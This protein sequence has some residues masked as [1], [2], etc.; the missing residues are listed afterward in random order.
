MKSM[1]IAA[2]LL[3][4]FSVFAADELRDAVEAAEQENAAEC[5]QVERNYSLCLGSPKACRYTV[6]YHCASRFGNFLLKIKVK[7]K[8]RVPGTV[9]TDVQLTRY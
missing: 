3:M 7:T 1:I 4:S 6:K 2:T 8:E 5:T 9:V